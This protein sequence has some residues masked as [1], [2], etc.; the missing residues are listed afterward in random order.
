[1]TT[2]GRARSVDPTG[3]FLVDVPEYFFHLLHQALRR[4]D[5]EFEKAL[6]PSGLSLTMWRVLVLV[7]RTEPCTMNTLAR[8]STF[9]RTTLTRTVDQMVADGL[10]DRATPPEDRRQVQLTL[11]DQARETY[12]VGVRLLIDFNRKAL[13]GVSETR[14]RE[15][16][17]GL[18]QI[19][20]N[21]IE[22]PALAEGVLTLSSPDPERTRGAA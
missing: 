15:M 22:D 17:R 8:M 18:H 19:V 7:S 2:E 21:L 10:I 16:T 14:L 12:E 3:E 20:A 9:E 4:R 1:M 5:V 13:G 11:T 6:R